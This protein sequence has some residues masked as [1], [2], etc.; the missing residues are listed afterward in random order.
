MNGLLIR[1]KKL[2][3]HLQTCGRFILLDDEGHVVFQSVSL[4]LPWLENI[5]NQSCIPTG[6]YTVSKVNSPKFGS[7]LKIHQVPG[8]S[9]ILIHPGNYTSEIKGCVLL[10]EHF[11]DIN[12]DQ[13]TDVT[14]SRSTISRLNEIADGFELNII[15]V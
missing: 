4:E 3:N 15:Q 14:N 11:A 12:N 8:R 10:G 6:V 9:Q 1:L 7:V 5:Q 13:I 2:S